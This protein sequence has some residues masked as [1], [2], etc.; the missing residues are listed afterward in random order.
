MLRNGAD[1]PF[2]CGSVVSH[3]Q[4][5]AARASHNDLLRLQQDEQGRRARPTTWSHSQQSYVHLLP[6]MRTFKHGRLEKD[7][8]IFGQF[9][10]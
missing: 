9:G 6:W 5:L 10:R 8:P 2:E 7:N 3:P 4:E 1:I